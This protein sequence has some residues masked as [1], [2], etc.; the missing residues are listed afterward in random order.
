[1]FDAALFKAWPSA[2]EVGVT[3]ACVVKCPNYTY[4]DF[5]C[6]AAMSLYRQLK[7]GGVVLSGA[8]TCLL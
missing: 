5:Q 2:K 4:G 3:S 6:N 7:V 8:Q 1:M